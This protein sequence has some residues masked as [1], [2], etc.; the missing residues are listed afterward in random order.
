[1]KSLIFG[2]GSYLG[3]S[4]LN[5][6]IKSNVEAYG[7]SEHLN[8]KNLIKTNYKLE[9]L[10]Q[11]ISQYTPNK[12]YDFKTFKVSS[13][14]NHFD[15]KIDDMFEKNNNIIT[16]LKNEYY[17]DLE[18]ILIST[19]LLNYS[20]NSSHPYIKIKMFQE[21]TYSNLQNDGI[22]AKILRLPN[23]LGPGDLN[24]S[25]LIPFCIGSYFVNQK[26]LL[27]SS[28]LVLREYV[29]L[30]E[31][32]DFI[33]N[34]KIS[35]KKVFTLTN[36]EVI[37][38]LNKVFLEKKLLKVEVDWNTNPHLDVLNSKI[39]KSNININQQT[40]TKYFHN[41]VDWYLDN[42]DSVIRMFNFYV[43]NS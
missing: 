30:D 25:R 8:D 31:A 39:I 33:K 29:Y 1:M 13:N 23:V 22:N 21:K 43:K 15:K 7:L 19:R 37:N 11:I 26:I 36:G 3:S 20:E 40:L 12:I 38:L 28:E 16:S 18:L 35:E 24:F 14:S 4:F 5:Y 27:N 17:K 41:I 34:S 6:L 32:L 2:A 9:A 42:K 10:S